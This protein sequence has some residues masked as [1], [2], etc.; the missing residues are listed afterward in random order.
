MSAPRRV[1]AIRL[2]TI[3]DVIMTT[4]AL[5]ALSDSGCEVTLLT[6]SF[7]SGLRPMM[8]YLRDFVTLDVPWMKSAERHVVAPS[9]HLKTLE[10]LR[11][12]RFDLAV[13]FTVSTQDPAPAAYLAYL[14]GIPRVAAHVNTKLYGLVSDPIADTDVSGAQ[15]HE[16]QRQLELVAALGFSSHNRRLRLDIP[17]PSRPVRALLERLA[18][19]PWCLLH[20]GASAQARRY[21]AEQ[22][23]DVVDLLEREGITVVL[24]GG[25]QDREQC[26]RIAS[27]CWQPPVRADGRFTL[28]EFAAL[29]KAAPAA[30][31]CNSAAAHLAAA[32][33]T[34]VVT[35]YAGTNSQHAPWSDTA[36]VLRHPTT[37][38]WCFSSVCRYGVPECT[39]AVAPSTV[40]QA[41]LRSLRRG[42]SDGRSAEVAS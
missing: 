2:D 3:G 11:G 25:R 1:L 20:P 23:S 7:A 38:A 41:T 30:V 40:V 34:P 37:C 15:R 12:G 24:A 33:D 26:T 5:G 13:V 8:P 36:A 28:A 35:L 27:A 17:A 39:A 14:C 18:G 32:A 22:W 16:V 6:S 29:V 19:R 9:V 4:P 21:P 10:H 31:T 42:V